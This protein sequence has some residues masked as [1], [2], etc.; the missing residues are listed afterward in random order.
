MFGTSNNPFD[1]SRTTGGS[2]GGSAGALAVGFTPLELGSDIGGSIRNPSHS[3]GTAGHKT[4]YGL[5]PAIGQ[6]PG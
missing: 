3:C 1:V 4:S 5:I 6:I 2:S